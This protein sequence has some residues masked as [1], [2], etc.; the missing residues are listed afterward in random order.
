[1]TYKDRKK[2]AVKQLKI[3]ANYVYDGRN[4]H[5]KIARGERVTFTKPERH[6]GGAWVSTCRGGRY[7]LS[8]F[9]LLPKK[10]RRR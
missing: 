9:S 1:M 5:P 7:V 8:P 10:D 2:A 3:G 4:G 6:A